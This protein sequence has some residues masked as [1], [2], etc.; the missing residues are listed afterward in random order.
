MTRIFHITSA[1]DAAEARHTGEYRPRDFERDTFVHCSYRSQLLDVAN[2]L[3]RGRADLVLLEIDVAKLECPVVEENLDG[4]TAL[5][6]H[7]YGV[8]PMTAVV[9]VHSFP[10]D[11]QGRFTR[12]DF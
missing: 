1:Q 3:F 4:G 12:V 7:V 9:R 5:F 10:C 11:E 2:R 8:I 6:P